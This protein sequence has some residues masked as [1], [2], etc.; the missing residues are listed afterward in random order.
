MNNVWKL[1]ALALACCLG[2]AC[3]TPGSGSGRSPGRPTPGAPKGDSTDILRAGEKIYIT[4]SDIPGGPGGGEVTIS[5]DG[6][7][8]LH[9]DQTFVAAGKTRSQLEAEI[10]ARYVPGFYTKMTVTVKQ[11]DRFVYVGGFVKAPNR[12]PYTPGLTLLKAI[13]AAGDFSEFGDK[14]KVTITRS[15]GS[16]ET[17]DCKKAIETPSL[18]RPLLPGDRVHVPRRGFFQP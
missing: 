3:D 13:A 18:D 5:E 7:I 10:R 4:L 2:L 14:T 16:T 1:L 17:I 6:K 11:E 15:D 9:L 12:Y 8:T